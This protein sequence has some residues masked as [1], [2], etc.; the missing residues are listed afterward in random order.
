MTASLLATSLRYW[1]R[2]KPIYR[3]SPELG[4]R[5]V[6]ESQDAEHKKKRVVAWIDQFAAA[7]KFDKVILHGPH[8]EHGIFKE[9][10]RNIDRIRTRRGT[11]CGED[12]EGKY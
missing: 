3:F 2:E 10:S 11:W 5:P 6:S 9:S 7:H 4:Y 1:M 8:T 12:G